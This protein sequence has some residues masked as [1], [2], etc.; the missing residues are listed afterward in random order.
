MACMGARAPAGCGPAVT[1]APAGSGSQVLI[2]TARTRD[3]TA[4]SAPNA[5]T[6]SHIDHTDARRSHS[7]SSPG[8]HH[9]E[10]PRPD[11]FSHAH[12]GATSPASGS[13]RLTGGSHTRP[14]N[15]SLA[16]HGCY[17]VVGPA[18]ICKRGDNLVAHLFPGGRLE[19]L[20]RD[21]N[22]TSLGAVPPAAS[23]YGGFGGG[24][25]VPMPYGAFA[26]AAAAGAEH[27]A[28]VSPA[29]PLAAGAGAGG[30]SAWSAGASLFSIADEDAPPA[31]AACVSVAAAAGGG[32]GA[33]AAAAPVMS[34]GVGGGHR[35]Q[36]RPRGGAASG[37]GGRG[38]SGGGGGGCAAGGGGV[39][40]DLQ[41]AVH[42]LNGHTYLSVRCM[43][44]SAVIE[45]GADAQ[46]CHPINMTPPDAACC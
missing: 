2:F 37:G 4:N 31:A 19:L 44:P 46:L 42:H 23:P 18:R 6:A 21:G 43:P 8:S 30:E 36:Q 22:A 25:G 33:A 32:G 39:D 38:E 11:D 12:T 41:P 5:D 34:S 26:A 29:A 16:A 10:P 40:L 45:L 1:R 7:L 17:R 13:A 20:D 9:L 24:G 3:F 27:Y 15:S 14:A 35:Q 28:V